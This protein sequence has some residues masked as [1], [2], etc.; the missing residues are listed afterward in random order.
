[1]GGKTKPAPTAKKTDEEKAAEKAAKALSKAQADFLKAAKQGDRAKVVAAISSGIVDINYAN[2]RGQTA[3]HYAAA[4]GHRKLLQYLHANGADF[5]LQTSDNH[6]F[7]PLA[8]ANFVGETA[9]AALIEALQSGAAI[10]I[11]DASDDDDDDDDDDDGQQGGG[12]ATGASASGQLVSTSSKSKRRPASECAP[13]VGPTP[14]VASPEDQPGA[15]GAPIDTAPYVA[16]RSDAID[17]SASDD[18]AY[19]HLRLVN[20]MQVMLVSDATC[21]YAAA[22]MDVGVGSASDPDELPGLAHFLEVCG[23]RP[24]VQLQYLCTRPKVEEPRAH[25][26]RS[27]ARSIS[28]GGSTCSS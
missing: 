18:R 4:F 19:R 14:S 11:G 15:G 9:A 17:K 13:P 20:G 12:G 23:A 6:R 24:P 8:A 22:A 3:A 5:T 10:D 27:R 2:E 16:E 28:R 26:E 7:T 25:F 1:M 21:D